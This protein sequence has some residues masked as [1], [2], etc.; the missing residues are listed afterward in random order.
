MI[1]KIM[2]VVIVLVGVGSGNAILHDYGDAFSKSILFF[3]GQ[4]SGKLPATQRLTWRNNSALHDGHHQGVDLTGGYY[5]A[6]DNVKYNFPMAFSTTMMAWGVIEYGKT[7]GPEL[8]HALEAVR[9]STD[10]FLK[11]TA[12]P[13]VVYAQVGDPKADHN[14]WQRPEDIDT[15]RTVYVVS[16]NA[17]GSEVAAEIAAALAAGSLAFR[18]FGD[19]VYAKVLLKRASEVFQFADKYRGSYNDSI[20][21]GVCPFYCDYSGYQDELLWGAAWLYIASKKNLYWNYVTQNM[22]NF[23]PQIESAL[24]EF[25]WD[26]KH[27]GIN[28]LLSKLVL[29]NS[30]EASTPF[31]SYAD[32][33]ICSLVPDS[34]TKTVQFS[35]GG[36]LIKQGVCDL[37]HATALSFLVLAYARYL[38]KSPHLIRCNDKIITQTQLVGFT[39]QQVD[40]ILGSNP[41]GMSY[42]VGYGSKYPRRIHHRASSLPSLAQHSD[43]IACKAGTPYFLSAAANPNELTGAVVGGPEVDDSFADDRVD[44]SKSEPTTYIAAPLVGLL[45]YFKARSSH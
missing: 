9:W 20:G 40:Y 42:M 4:R 21:E 16:R 27:A 43:H 45:A 28:V 24:F 23:K 22:I 36:L 39:K 25:G 2:Y 31:L 30:M 15:P 29:N 38:K 17:P 37:Q 11:A 44:A 13:G 34:P 32:S 7:M 33:F 1:R 5:D 6:G 10:Y 3:E 26:A 14:C 12:T 18:A 19:K 41:L 35:P 8:V